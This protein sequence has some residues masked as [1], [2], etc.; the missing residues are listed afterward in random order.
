MKGRHPTKGSELQNGRPHASPGSISRREV[1]QLAGGA[2]TLA[3]I[4]ASSAAAATSPAPV[5]SAGTL[6]LVVNAEPRELTPDP[7]QSLLDV[8]RE[9]LDLTGT[10]KGCNQ[11]ACGACTVLVNGRRVVSCLTLAAMH[12]GAEITTIEGLGKE[13]EL[14]PLQAAFIEHEGMQCGFCTPGQIMSGVACI[15]EGHAGSPEEISFWMSGNICRC[16]AYPGIVA[17]VADAA[18]RT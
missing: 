3:A 18:A 7:R 4:P 14:H 11:G 12:E 1:L 2:A 13:G 6:R 15:A 8:L 17:A 5:A 10:K 9:T 16:G